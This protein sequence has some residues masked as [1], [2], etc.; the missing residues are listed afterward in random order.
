MECFI[1]NISKYITNCATYV[2]LTEY[3]SK[4]MGLF[5]VEWFLSNK[6]DLFSYYINYDKSKKMNRKDGNF[7][8]KDLIYSKFN[9]L[10]RW[11]NED[12]M[13]LYTLEHISIGTVFNTDMLEEYKEHT[14][15]GLRLAVVYKNPGIIKYQKNFQGFWDLTL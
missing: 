15:E 10:P 13:F 4:N 11:L 8:N 7:D 14:Y 6:T 5:N 1:E 2:K 12:C 3:S 9:N